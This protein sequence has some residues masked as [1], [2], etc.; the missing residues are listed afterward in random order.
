MPDGGF[1]V[2][3]P[4]ITRIRNLVSRIIE[5]LYILIEIKVY[6]SIIEGLADAGLD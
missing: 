2:L 1:R 4:K 3:N 5:F 6:G